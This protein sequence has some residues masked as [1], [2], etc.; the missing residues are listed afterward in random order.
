MALAT[1]SLTEIVSWGVLYY[2]FGVFL[3]IMRLNLGLSAVQLTTAFSIALFVAGIAGIVVGRLMDSGSPRLLMTAGSVLAA[4]LV[5]AWSQARSVWQLDVIWAGIGVAMALT[6]YVPAFALIAKWF[7]HDRSRALTRLTLFG[8]LASFIFSP[9]SAWLIQLLGWRRALLALAAILAALTIPTHALLLRRPPR[10]QSSVT[11]P[12]RTD[13]RSIVWSTTFLRLG[14]GFSLAA[15][16]GTAVS[17]HLVSFLMASGHKT[18]YAATI[19]GLVGIGQVPGRLIY[20]AAVR[21]VSTR[22]AT[23]AVFGLCAVSLLMLT[24]S[25]NSTALIVV[26]LLFGMTSGMTTLARATLIGDLYGSARYGTISGAMSACTNCAQSIA[27]ALAAIVYLVAR[28]YPALFA[29]LGLAYVAGGI[30][31]LS[32]PRQMGSSLRLGEH[33]RA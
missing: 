3:P 8:A 6:L 15:L 24:L 26:A 22:T 13:L 11:P 4:T 21:V 28:G 19:A 5:V 17:V 30:L 23:G 9:L 16:A 7:A 2:A 10:E 32:S 18:A 20:G 31:V 25:V 29:L 33:H 14:A 27:P 12:V 1:L